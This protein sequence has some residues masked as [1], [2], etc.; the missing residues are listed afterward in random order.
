MSLTKAEF[1]KEVEGCQG[2]EVIILL[3]SLLW[4]LHQIIGKGILLK[5]DT[6]IGWYLKKFY[7]LKESNLWNKNY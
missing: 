1:C 2:R 4:T 6:F 3:I 7:F 5:S